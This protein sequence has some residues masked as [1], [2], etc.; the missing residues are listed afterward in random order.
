MSHL[1]ID[2]RR[3]AEPIRLF[4][5]DFPEFCT[6]IS[7]MTLWHGRSYLPAFHGGDCRFAACADA[8][9]ASEGAAVVK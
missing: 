7:P 5:S 1:P 3:D 9:L 4:Q 8:V 6:Y 2:T